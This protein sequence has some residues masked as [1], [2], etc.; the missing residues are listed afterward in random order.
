MKYKDTKPPSWIDKIL[1]WFCSDQYLEE[2]QG[3]LHEWYKRRE[4]KS[5]RTKAR[6]FY[7]YDVIAYFRLFRIKE[8]N[9]MENGNNLLLISYFKM[10][11]RQFKR[12]LGYS[13]MNTFGLA[14]GIL[15]TLLISLFILDE[16]SYDK[17]HE[18]HDEIYRLINHNPE[19][20]T[21]AGMNSSAWKKPMIPFFP[22]ISDHTRLGHDV[23]VIKEGENTFLENDFYWA[24]DNFMSFFSF[25]VLSGDRETMLTEP[26]SIVL[27]RS[28]A[29]RYF[30]KE[31]VVGQLLP[32]KVYDGNKDFVMRVSG[33]I[34][35]IPGNSH[36]QFDLLGSMATTDEMYGE[37]EG[38]WNFNWVHSYVRIS[39]SVDVEEVQ[40]K[41]PAFFDEHRGEDAS[42]SQGIIFQP[43]SEV[44][45]YSKKVTG[46][47]A[48]GD[49]NYV[50]LF[51]FVAVL[52]VLAASINYVN[53]TTAKS[54]KRG[55]E[56]GMRKVFG[57]ARKQVTTQ[58]YMECG[59]QLV[60]AFTIAFAAALLL[61]PS[62][63]YVVDKSMVAT[64]LFQWPVLVVVA[65]LFLMVF[66]LSGIYPA[67]VMNRF[68]PIQVL[69]GNLTVLSSAGSW[70]RK[71]Q[72]LVQFAIATFLI[73]STIIVLKQ[74][75]LF[76]SHDVGFEAEQLII[77]PVDDREMQRKLMVIKDRMQRVPGVRDIAASGEKLPSAM[78]NTL[79]FR[80]GDMTDN[81]ML[82]IYGV[83]VDYDFFGTIGTELVMGRNFSSELPTD[84]SN[85][86]LINEAAFRQT[87]W[88]D[89]DDK[90]MNLD[91]NE[92]LVVGVVEDYN[93]HSL[94][95][96]VAPVAYLLIAPGRRMSPDN[97]ILRMELTNLS[98]SLDDLTS[99]W[100]E[101]SDQ[102][103]DFNFVDQSFAQLYGN[104][105]RFMRVVIGFS[106]VGVFLAVLGLIGLVSFTAERRSK[107]I[108][109]HKVLGASKRV[110][111]TKVGG[112]FFQIFIVSVLVGLP[113]SRLIM[114]RWLQGFAYR[115]EIDWVVFG[116]AAVISIVIVL[117]SIGIQALR[118]ARANP[119][120]YLSDH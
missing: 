45:L 81:D 119:T 21:M 33:V 67:V 89:L 93:Y 49:I 70:L 60:L 56:V 36:L 10:T 48:K 7:L 92:R 46:N 88:N 50:Y 9:D 16:L 28:K 113:L 13:V 37:F 86:V 114:E 14:V 6:L 52:I 44:R 120:R 103:F 51:G 110:I 64:D 108:S 54:T 83:A 85:A 107:E 12:N 97:L 53:L 34:A 109:I 5:G 62:F 80:W 4:Q 18:N 102:P 57:A 95:S 79:G 15:S 90:R 47:L 98:S 59:L 71:A 29:L 2:V 104:E 19:M 8:L 20:G 58:F 82:P 115:T 65:G 55:K 105:Q 106:F 32:I 41:V 43:L 38:Y 77:I 25:E 111:L 30:G 72:V 74:M 1:E 27:T 76:N 101:F 117:S 11:V 66:L 118:V 40:K 42:V 84:S 39:G 91:G 96:S 31:D 78:N 3:D 99:I 112:Q 75:E 61:L 73:S 26:N 68:R 35:D 17:F 24:D 87:G 69:K 116:L 100:S 94:H 23:V 22:E 63:S